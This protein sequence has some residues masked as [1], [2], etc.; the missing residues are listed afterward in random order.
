[1]L[2]Y[3]MELLEMIYLTTNILKAFR[4]AKYGGRMFLIIPLDKS[5]GSEE[6]VSKAPME[7]YSVLLKE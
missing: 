3:I 1:M 6:E 5:K 4:L 2:I 7:I